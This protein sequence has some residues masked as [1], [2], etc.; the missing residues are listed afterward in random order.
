MQLVV[1]EIVKQAMCFSI[2]CIVIPLQLVSEHTCISHYV[3]V[4]GQDPSAINAEAILGVEYHS[5][6]QKSPLIFRLLPHNDA[7]EPVL[8]APTIMKGYMFTSM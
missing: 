5:S 2:I 8:Q 1:H 6:S 3:P 7:Q 4:H